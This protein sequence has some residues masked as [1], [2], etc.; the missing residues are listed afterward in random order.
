METLLAFLVAVALTTVVGCF[1][2]AVF[3]VKTLVNAVVEWV[4]E[5]A[6]DTLIQSYDATIDEDELDNSHV[7]STVENIADDKFTSNHCRKLG[8]SVGATIRREMGCPKYTVANRTIAVQRIEAYR[9][10]KLLHLR[11]CYV[12]SFIEHALFYVFQPAPYEVRAFERLNSY[13]ADEARQSIEGRVNWL[14]GWLP[15][16]I[17]EA[18]GLHKWVGPGFPRPKTDADC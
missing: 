6:K 17:Q 12:E 8:R 1:L 9:K 7:V 3:L 4:S 13:A 14:G 15:T 2:L 18:F 11:L 10:E 5:S 16:W